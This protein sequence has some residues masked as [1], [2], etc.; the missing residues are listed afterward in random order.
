ML[1]V[2]FLFGFRVNEIPNN[3]FILDS[4]QP[5]ICIKKGV[6]PNITNTSRELFNELLIVYWSALQLCVLAT[7]ITKFVVFL[8][9]LQKTEELRIVHI[10]HSNFSEWKGQSNDV[11]SKDANWL[12]FTF[13][14][15]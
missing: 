5:F 10:Y 15:S 4:H 6:Q 12:Q 8:V 14:R 1:V 11:K 2:N 9:S 3:T 7:K 13:S